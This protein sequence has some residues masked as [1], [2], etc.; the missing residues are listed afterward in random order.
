MDRG[1]VMGGL[2]TIAGCCAAS[3]LALASA[4]WAQPQAAKY[5]AADVEGGS[6][7]YTAQCQL[8]HGPNGDLVSGVE[9]RRGQFHHAVSDEDIAKT[10]TTGIA[11]AGMPAFSLQPQE[12]NS[13]IAYIRAGFDLSGTAVKVGDPARGKTIFAGK[14]GCAA[15]HR[16][17]GVGPRTAP[18]LSD[19]GSSRS[20]AALQRSITDPTSEMI[21]ID[22]PV[23]IV[24]KDGKTYHGRRMNEDTFTVQI[25]DDKEQLLSFTKADLKQYEVGKTSPM[26]AATG[27][28]GGEQA[29]L[30]GYLMTLKEASK[31]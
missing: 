2:G 21:P 4:A 19:V 5:T 16:V 28:T 12:V 6:R 31:P 22:K 25:I 29:D 9:L 17:N 15:C 26:P 14:G 20:A 13:L 18:D 30:I 8:C 3:L 11:T 27:L 24:T 7:L 10:I 23:L 1:D